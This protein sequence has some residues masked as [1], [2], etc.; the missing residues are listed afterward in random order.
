MVAQETTAMVL[1]A[2]GGPVI[3]VS[4]PWV[5]LRRRSTILEREITQG[6]RSGTATFEFETLA[7]VCSDSVPG[8]IEA[9][10]A[11][12]GYQRFGHYVQNG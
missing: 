7:V 12:P 10:L 9:T 8:I 3:T 1:P 5:P 2:P 4:G 11:R 6:G